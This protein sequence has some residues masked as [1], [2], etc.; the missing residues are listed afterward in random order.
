MYL[1]KPLAKFRQ[2]REQLNEASSYAFK[3]KYL[4]IHLKYISMLYFYDTVN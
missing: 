2:H 1:C 3:K 4:E